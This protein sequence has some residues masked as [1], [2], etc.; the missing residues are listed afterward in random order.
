MCCDWNLIPFKSAMSIPAN[1]YP[2]FQNI[3]HL[4]SFWI[5]VVIFVSRG[6][7]KWKE[8]EYLCIATATHFSF[9][10]YP[11]HCEHSANMTDAVALH[12][13]STEY[14]GVN[15]TKMVYKELRIWSDT[16]L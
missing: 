2:V 14:F 8:F 15:F 1:H 16:N 10:K 9:G 7:I 4:S 5:K 13:R 12:Q 3:A 11:D 6:R